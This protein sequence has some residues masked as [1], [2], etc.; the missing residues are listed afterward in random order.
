MLLFSFKK[1]FILAEIISIIIIINFNIKVL[2]KEIPMGNDP[3]FKNFY[4]ENK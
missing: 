4:Y 3:F 2:Q 1:L